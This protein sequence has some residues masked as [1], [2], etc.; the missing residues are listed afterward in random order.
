MWDATA[1]DGHELQADLFGADVPADPYILMLQALPLV[2]DVG[3]TT[4]R[5]PTIDELF[6]VLDVA[7]PGTVFQLM[8]NSQPFGVRREDPPPGLPF[9]LKALKVAD[10]PSPGRIEVIRA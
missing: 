2:D 3:I 9:G 4:R 5:W 8:V 6:S 10:L 1:P 7:A